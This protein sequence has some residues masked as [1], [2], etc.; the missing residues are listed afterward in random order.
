[1]HPGTVTE[2]LLSAGCVRLDLLEAGPAEFQ[3][4]VNRMECFS[5][6]QIECAVILRSCV[7][8]IRFFTKF[9][10]IK[11]VATRTQITQ[12]IRGIFR[13]IEQKSHRNDYR[14]SVR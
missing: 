7:L 10:T 13:R 8:S 14:Q 11:A 2:L 12:L 9:Y 1:M 3:L 4:R 6:L 5:P